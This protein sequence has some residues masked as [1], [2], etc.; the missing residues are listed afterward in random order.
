M[1]KTSLMFNREDIM[2]SQQHLLTL[3]SSR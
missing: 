1:Q 3:D 2:T